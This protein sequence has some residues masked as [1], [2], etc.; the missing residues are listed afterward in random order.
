MSNAK[1]LVFCAYLSRD[2]D[3]LLLAREVD[4]LMHGGDAAAC[5]T[6][7]KQLAGHTRYIWRHCH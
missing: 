3:P 7:I 4:Q 6:I 1:F 5:W 2:I